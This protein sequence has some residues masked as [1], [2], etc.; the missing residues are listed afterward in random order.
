MDGKMIVVAARSLLKTECSPSRFRYQDISSRSI[1]LTAQHLNNDF[2]N[3]KY[4]ME[5]C[6]PIMGS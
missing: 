4:W 2:T 5:K 1:V 6:A 3:K